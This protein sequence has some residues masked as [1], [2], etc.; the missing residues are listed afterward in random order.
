MMGRVIVSNELVRHEIFQPELPDGH[1]DMI[2]KQGKK[3]I[4]TRA[5]VPFHHHTVNLVPTV[6]ADGAIDGVRISVS[7]S[8]MPLFAIR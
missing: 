5:L 4:G 8:L 2:Q 3:Q 1:G 7:P 6:D